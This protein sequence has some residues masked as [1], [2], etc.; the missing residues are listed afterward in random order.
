MHVAI[1]FS[2]ADAKAFLEALGRGG[3]G[4]VERALAAISL[5]HAN[6]SV[7]SDIARITAAVEKEVGVDAFNTLVRQGLTV[8]YSSVAQRATFR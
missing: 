4:E 5:E 1:V 3:M 6:A 8:E 7:Q 2:D